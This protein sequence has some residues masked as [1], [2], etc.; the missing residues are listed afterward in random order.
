[1]RFRRRLSFV[2]C[3]RTLGLFGFAYAVWAAGC[4][5]A[6]A[7]TLNTL[8][9]F[10]G[11]DGVGPS[12][13]LTQGRD[14]NLRGTVGGGGSNDLGTAFAITPGGVL[15]Y[16]N[17]DGTNGGAPGGG[18]LLGIDNNFYGTTANGGANGLGVVYKASPTGTLAVL[19]SFDKADGS[20]PEGSLIQ[21]TDGNFYGTTSDGGSS[22]N[23]SAGCG[24]VFKIAPGGALTTLYNFDATH[25]ALP[26]QGMVQGT[27]SNFYGTTIQGGTSTNCGG[28]C[29][30]VF[31]ITPG[32]QLI[33]VHNF[34]G[35]DGTSPYGP[36]IEGTDGNFYGTTLNTI[37]RVSP[38][39]AFTNLYT[40]TGTTLVVA[41][42]VEGT[43]GNFYGVNAEGGSSNNCGASGCGT[44]FQ[45]TPSGVLTT[46]YNFSGPDGQFPDGGLLQHTNGK[47]YGTTAFGGGNGDGTIFSL[48]MGFGPFV[49]FVRRFG[50][51][52]SGV[53]ILGTGLTGATAITFNGVPATTFSVF[54]DSFMEAIVPAGATTGPVQV[55]APGGTLTSNVNLQIVP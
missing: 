39:G 10:D 15:K 9:N 23:C 11:T 52:G 4:L 26:A 7:Q 47:F 27:D 54:S 6:S 22:T 32:G 35:S 2:A 51:V 38:G 25:G 14:G 20:N 44:I 21:G 36:P 13:T 1:M 45:I 34:T 49:T 18:L 5:V 30:T 28:G 48:D 3:R 12:I 8:H 24:T 16:I 17:F 33:T 19:I 55:T 53:Q 42:L 41:P 37:F 46:L 50:R 40:L 43:D 31:R 29:G